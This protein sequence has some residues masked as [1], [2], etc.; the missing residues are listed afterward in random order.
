MGIRMKRLFGLFIVLLIN[1]LPLHLAVAEMRT[2]DLGIDTVFIP[3]NLNSQVDAIITVRG[4]LKGCDSW[5]SVSITNETAF[6]HI[7][8]AKAKW[9]GVCIGLKPYIHEIN[10]GRLQPGVHTIRITTSSQESVDGKFEVK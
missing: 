10:L 6:F 1:N 9:N 8:A 3:P 4:I 5:E 7:I 2:S